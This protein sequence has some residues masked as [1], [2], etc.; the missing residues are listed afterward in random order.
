EWLARDLDRAGIGYVR[1]DNALPWI[2]DFGR[3]QKM[4][5]RQVGF[6]FR[7]ALDSIVR[8][9]DPA[10]ASRF[11][12]FSCDYYWS[13]YQSEWATDYSFRDASTL[14]ERYPRLIRHALS[15]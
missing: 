15:T 9:I 10:H 8:K 11:Q 7:R 6:D 2:D 12:K 14:R 4:M 3:A 5:D 13:T 1:A